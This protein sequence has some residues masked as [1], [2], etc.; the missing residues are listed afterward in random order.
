MVVVVEGQPLASNYTEDVLTRLTG[1]RSEESEWE[2]SLTDPQSVWW[3]SEKRI[4]EP[5]KLMG[6]ALSSLYSLFILKV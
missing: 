3:C 5:P 4:Y 1:V 2:R 6:I